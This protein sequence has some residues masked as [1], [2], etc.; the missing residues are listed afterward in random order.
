MSIE[1]NRIL[2]V[3]DPTL[4][5]QPC[6]IRACEL[7]RKFDAAL[8]LFICDY[9]QYLSGERFFDSPGLKK[10]RDSFIEDRRERLEN[11]AKRLGAAGYKVSYDACWDYPLHDG[12]VRKVLASKPDLV[13]KD[14]HRHGKIQRSLFT[15]TDWHLVR[16]C[17]VPL[18]LTKLA[19]DTERRTIAAAVDPLNEHDKPASLDHQILRYARGLAV[20]LG[21]VYHVAHSYNPVAITTA[22]GA[23]AMQ[24]AGAGL[25]IDDIEAGVRAEHERGLKKLLDSYDLPE[26]H[27]HLLSGATHDSLENFVE[28]VEARLLVMGALARHA[29]KR[30]FVGS[31]AEKVLGDVNCDVLVLK[32][33]GFV[34]PVEAD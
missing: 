24:T 15:N 29:I 27:V 12:I 30:I 13:I 8:E 5:E 16:D 2:V 31:T 14:T 1:L 3:I 7:A 4:Q 22:A 26:D 11:E 20:G 19:A 10:S 17:P 32:P 34:S 9:N 21:T 18:M 6:M 23:P 28:S 25:P 33:D